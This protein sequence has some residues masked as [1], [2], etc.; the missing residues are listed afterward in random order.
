MKFSYNWIKKYVDIKYSPDKLAEILTLKT[1]EVEEIKKLGDDYILEIKILPNRSDLLSH[2]GIAREISI[3]TGSKLKELDLDYKEI[4]EKTSSLIAVKVED[5]ELC[6]RYTAQIIKNIKIADSPAWLKQILSSLGL[7]PINNIVDATNYVMLEMGQ[8]L[9]AFDYD[10]IAGHKIIVR[11]A[12]ADEKIISLDEAR[13]TY[14]LSPDVLVISDQEKPLAIAGIK[15]G[16]GSEI[17]DSTRTIIIESANF[18][19]ANIRRTSDKL[20]LRTD[21]SIRF[22][23]GLD[24]NLAGYAIYR[25]TRLIQELAGGEITSGNVTVY[26]KEL[27]PWK[28]AIN[29][30]YISSLIG[31]NI[32]DAE[33]KNILNKIFLSAKAEKEKY[34]VGVPTYR[35]DIQTSEDIIEE[36]ARIYGYENIKS[37]PPVMPLYIPLESKRSDVWD[38]EQQIKARE[39]M[40]NILKSL[41]F[42]ETYNYS[43]M[44]DE[45]KE[46]FE[47]TD[48]PELLNP[49]SHQYRYMRSGLIPNLV[50]VVEKNLRFFSSVKLFEIGNSFNQKGDLIGEHEQIAGVLVGQRSFIEMK[51]LVESFLRQLSVSDFEFD[52]VVD[53]S[54]SEK[55]WFHPGRVATIK[56]DNDIVGIIGDL[57]PKI[58]YRLGFKDGIEVSQFSF[59]SPL[60][61]KAMEGE[62]EFEPIPKYPAIV[63]DI[64]VLVDKNVRVSQILNKINGADTEQIV[65]DVDVFDTYETA[66]TQNE[67]MG[68][69]EAD[70]TLREVS[71][72]RR[73]IA[74]HV[75][76]R[77]DDHTLTDTEVDKVEKNIKHALEEGLGAEVR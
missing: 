56:I 37:A 54:Y 8:P 11:N 69:E 44:S 40:R 29:K 64:S 70:E 65:Q 41:G 67:K 22:S 14:N 20:N 74:F 50:A 25:V 60:L 57:N 72:G 27:K 62:L 12:K 35:L 48:A 2:Y 59:S 53:K 42:I 30:S 32:P 39:L 26:P 4:K 51:G 46:A 34:V 75:I 16:Y 66:E 73:S 7:K 33:I 10:K 58:K 9:H 38:V 28:I 3:L 71:S 47:I 36:I 77:S 18:N 61:V 1:A 13:T 63:R 76:Y 17:S 55:K 68:S 31:A 23:Y 15:G 21:A 5:T 52:D 45:T 24:P 43:F 49:A 6:P 19:Q